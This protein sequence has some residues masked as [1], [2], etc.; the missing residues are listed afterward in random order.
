MTWGSLW[1]EFSGVSVISVVVEVTCIAVGVASLVASVIVGMSCIPVGVASLIPR[2][3]PAASA[4]DLQPWLPHA[5]GGAELV[6]GG[7]EA[8]TVGAGVIVVDGAEDLAVAGLG[9]GGQGS[10][11]GWVTREVEEQ[12]GGRGL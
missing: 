10:V 4:P 6:G 9:V 3:R 2:P 7:V 8:S 11:L 1:S 12:R 5:V